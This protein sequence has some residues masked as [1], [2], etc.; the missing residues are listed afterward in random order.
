[1]TTAKR[2]AIVWM[3]VA[4]G[5][6]AAQDAAH[7][8][9]DPGG[10]TEVITVTDSTIEHRWFTGRA[11]VTVVTRANLAAS[12]R[13]TL[14]DIL[15]SLPVQC[16]AGNA[17]VNVP[18]AVPAVLKRGRLVA[19]V[20]IGGRAAAS[21]GVACPAPRRPPVRRALSARPSGAPGGGAG[22]TG[23]RA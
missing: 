10:N 7:T 3:V 19:S 21:R 14:G 8:D 20:A 4:A 16:N 5:P 22:A 6:A 1:M 11:P 9:Q 17:Q 13:A 2:A 12:G 23:A 18:A 15:Q